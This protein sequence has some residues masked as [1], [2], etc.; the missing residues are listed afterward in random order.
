MANTNFNAKINL[1]SASL[2]SGDTWDVQFTVSDGEGIYS[3]LDALV[4]DILFLDTSPWTL[5]TITRYK[6]S[7]ITSQTFTTVDCQIDL[8]DDNTGVDLSFVTGLD[9]FICRPTALLKFAI[10]PS[11][12]IQ[13]LPDKFVTYVRNADFNKTVDKTVTGV[14]IKTNTSSFSIVQHAPVSLRSDGGIETCVATK[15]L[16]GIALT[17]IANGNSGEVRVAGIVPN[18]LVGLSASNND[19]VFVSSSGALSL[20]QAIVSGTYV[21]RAGYACGTGN[22]LRIS[23]LKRILNP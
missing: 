1:A 10:T 4:N 18:A 16:Y 2:V 11:P 7:S 22:D 5:G 23:I 14:E 21:L 19:P 9:S 3:G 6:I 17:P 13:L 8:D 20:S 15:E 12:G